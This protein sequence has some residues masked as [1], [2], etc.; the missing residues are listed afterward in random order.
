MSRLGDDDAPRY[1]DLKDAMR[2]YAAGGL[3]P[4]RERAV[5]SVIAATSKFFETI[6]IVPDETYDLGSIVVPVLGPDGKVVVCLRA[7]QLRPRV[8]G[9]E[10]LAWVATLEQA[11][12]AISK[13]LLGEGRDDYTAYLSAFPGDFMM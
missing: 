3:T 11:A 9:H 2:E 7:T 6:E 4:A 13:D 1:A 8:Q 10:V 12:E 5:R